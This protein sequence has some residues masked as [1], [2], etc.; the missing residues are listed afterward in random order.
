MRSRAL[1]ATCGL[2][3]AMLVAACGVS[4]NTYYGNGQLLVLSG[5]SDANREREGLWVYF[6]EDGSVR[7]DDETIDGVVYQRTGVYELASASAKAERMTAEFR[8]HP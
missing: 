2:A 3:A 4:S 8:R 1:L 6:N 7:L 5:A